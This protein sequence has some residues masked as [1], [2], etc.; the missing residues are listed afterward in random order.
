[1]GARR[2]TA[3]FIALAGAGALVTGVA[4]FAPYAVAAGTTRLV[5]TSGTDTGDCVS[6]PCET[7]QYA[8]DQADSGDTVSVGAGTYAQSVQITKSLTLEGAGSTGSGRTTISGD[9][10]SGDT[11]ITVRAIDSPPTVT[12]KDLDVSG[13]GDEDG[14]FVQDADVTVEDSVVSNNDSHGI[15]IVGSS[16]VEILDVTADDNGRNGVYVHNLREAPSTAPTLV[17]AEPSTTVSNSD[18]SGNNVSGLDVEAGAATVDHSTINSNGD[19]GA[20]VAA[21]TLDITN[22][23][24]DANSDSGLYVDN[25]AQIS[26][27]T[28]TVSNSKPLEDNEG[29]P[30]GAGVVVAP[31]GRALVDTSTVFG[32]TGQGVL[33]L[34]GTV[35]IDNSTISGTLQP[36][37]EGSESGGI[38]ELPYGGVAVVQTV[39]TARMNAIR[40]AHPRSSRTSATVKPHAAVLP[41]T[42][43]TGSIVA[44]NTT[45]QDC[46]GD[47]VDGGYNLDS[48]GSCDWSATGSISSGDPKLGPLADNGGPTMTLLPAKGSDAIDAIPTGEANCSVDATDQRAVSRPQGASCDIGAVEVAQPSVVISPDSLPDGTVG[49]PYNVALSA[50][51]G[52]GAP[53]EFSLVSGDNLPP[54]L[55]LASDGTISGTPTTPGTFP[56][57]V[58]VDDPT[59]KDYTIV[60]VA[61]ATSSVPPSSSAPPSPTTP[62]PSST[63]PVPS[64]SLPTSATP[65]ATTLPVANTGA[66]VGQMTTLGTLAFLLG[67][68]L[69]L[70]TVYSGRRY[71]RT[72]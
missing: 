47:V 31:L 4:L 69:L 6:T 23:T 8:V 71:R 53:Y 41:T 49:T 20:Y 5:S 64:S 70:G 32:N 63:T 44:D 17:L 54:G 40:A 2:I 1:M 12:I 3:R 29:E 51:G 37:D 33:S 34:R 72:H 66:P 56:F 11:S 39:T 21:A 35:T 36:A 62:V 45:L 9:Q 52:L 15:E 14:I 60:I 57:T 30:S 18:L 22:C 26:L 42:T 58:S 27:T 19:D 10:V 38:T 24:L 16:T 68:L 59:L 46:N 50:S 7:L 13:N 65:T 67:A 55:S 48:D 43:V 61:P 25:D 28:S